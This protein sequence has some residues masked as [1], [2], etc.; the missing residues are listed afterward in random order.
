MGRKRDRILTSY[1]LMKRKFY[2]F[3]LIVYKLKILLL[4]IFFL[5]QPTPI[6]PS[7][8]QNNEDVKVRKHPYL[9]QLIYPLL[10][11]VIN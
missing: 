11:E 9:Q 8:V 1:I 6:E 2:F 3:T 5:F 4:S 10:S 7:R